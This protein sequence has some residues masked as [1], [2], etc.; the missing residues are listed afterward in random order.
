MQREKCERRI[1]SDVSVAAWSPDGGH[2]AFIRPD[3]PRSASD[4]WHGPI[5]DEGDAFGVL[6]VADTDGSHQ[7]ELAKDASEPAWRP[8]R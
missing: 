4:N 8:G 5:E 3:S 2:F 6:W 1:V 7:L